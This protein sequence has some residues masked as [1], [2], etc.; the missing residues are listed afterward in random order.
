MSRP[1]DRTPF[2]DMILLARAHQYAAR[3]SD[4]ITPVRLFRQVKNE[5]AEATPEQ[6]SH[7]TQTTPTPLSEQDIHLTMEVLTSLIEAHLKSVAVDILT[8][9]NLSH[10]QYNR[11]RHIL[12]F[13]LDPET[14]KWAPKTLSHQNICKL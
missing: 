8:F 9:V 12:S 11:L 4:P 7:G 1:N 5:E 3:V 13:A 10:Q 2:T 14:N 6:S